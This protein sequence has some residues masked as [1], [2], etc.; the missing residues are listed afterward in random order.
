MAIIITTSG[1]TSTVI[2]FSCG[3]QMCK[4]ETRP[5]V[6]KGDSP[7]H[8]PPHPFALDETKTSGR[9]RNKQT[10]K[11]LSGRDPTSPEAASHQEI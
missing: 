9:F 6:L 10:N 3:S 8:P 4:E 5:N 11:H 7:I 1:I 2:E